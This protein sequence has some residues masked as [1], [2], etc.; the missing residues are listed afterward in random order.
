MPM[1]IEKKNLKLKTHWFGGGLVAKS[2]LILVTPS[3]DSLKLAKK[4][5]ERSYPLR[6][7][8]TVKMES[9]SHSWYRPNTT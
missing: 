7:I 3:E 1:S 5:K 8:L 4:K 6:Q 9:I 2:C